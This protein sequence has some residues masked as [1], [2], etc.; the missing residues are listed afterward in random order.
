M[1]RVLVA[2]KIPF[3]NPDVL[4]YV[5]TGYVLSQAITLGLYYYMSQKVY[6]PVRIARV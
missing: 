2:R 5:R 1:P 3:E 6:A 4:M